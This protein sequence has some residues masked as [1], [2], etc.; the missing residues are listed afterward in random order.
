MKPWVIVPLILLFW[1]WL[2][3][4]RMDKH[5]LNLWS[6]FQSINSFWSEAH[7][8]KAQLGRCPPHTGWFSIPCSSQDRSSYGAQL[9]MEMVAHCGNWPPEWKSFLSMTCNLILATTTQSGQ[10]TVCRHLETII[11]LL[12]TMSVLQV[13]L[14]VSL[15][16]P[17][18]TINECLCAYTVLCLPYLLNLIHLS[19]LVALFQSYYNFLKRDLFILERERQHMR[20][21]ETEHQSRGRAEGENLKQTPH[22]MWSLM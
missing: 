6:T 17:V 13:K 7:W 5:G 12:L 21:W 22:W 2:T 19:I 10:H 8:C 16:L 4:S 15:N 1:Y 20:E 14:G 3:I 18:P 9:V 11:S